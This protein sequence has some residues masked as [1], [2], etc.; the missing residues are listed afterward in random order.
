MTTPQHF[1]YTRA[2]YKGNPAL[3]ARRD[4]IRALWIA[5]PHMTA[6]QIGLTF[7][8]NHQSAS[9]M[10]P[11]EVRGKHVA[12]HVLGKT[13]PKLEQEVTLRRMYLEDAT[14]QEMAD[15]TNLAIKTVKRYLR[16]MGV[17]NQ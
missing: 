9:A 8:I 3:K 4:A 17:H 13:G 2:S 7:G 5:N 15:A 1:A 16:E 10:R 6:R 14:L 12:S 11:Y